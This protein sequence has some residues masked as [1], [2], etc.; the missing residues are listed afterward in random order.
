MDTPFPRVFRSE[1]SEYNSS[2]SEPNTC[3][4]QGD[5]VQL[6]DSVLPISDE[7][8]QHRRCMGGAEGNS[9]ANTRQLIQAGYRYALSLTHHHYDAEDLIQQA[10]MKCHHRY[11]KV[12]NRTILYTTIR[13]LYYDQLRRQKIVTFEPIADDEGALG[14]KVESTSPGASIDI[15]LLLAQLRT[16]EREAL[17]L[18]VVD[19]YSAKEIANIVGKPR[20]SILS[21]IH[22]ARQKL[23]KFAK[24]TTLQ[25]PKE[26]SVS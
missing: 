14:A 2:F 3:Q 25:S 6:V 20:N 5:L 11:G 1:R 21:L 18:N 23:T 22:R 13:N 7:F 9:S 12:K 16:E 24:S 8:P 15:D 4:P 19:G 17:Y 26:D 10:W